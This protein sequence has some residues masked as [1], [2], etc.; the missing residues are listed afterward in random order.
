[1]RLLKKV[2]RARIFCAIVCIVASAGSTVYGADKENC[3][4]CHKYRFLGRIDED[5]KRKNY[6][7]NENAYAMSLHKD[8]PCRDCHT[9]ITKLPHDPVTEEVNC[10]NECH[11]KPPFAE[12]NFS[13]KKIIEVYNQSVHGIKPNDPPELRAAKPY[14]KYCHLNPLFERVDE[15]TISYEKTLQRCLNCHQEKGVTEA[16]LHISHRLRHKT[17][18]SPQAIVQLCNVRC[19]ADVQLMKK[20][21]ISKESLEAVETYEKSIHGKAVAL[22]SN[23]AADCVS[24][25]STTAIHDI[26]KKDDPKSMVNKGNL[27]KTCNQCHEHVTEKFVKIDVHSTILPEEKPGLYYLNIALRFVMYGTVGA[28]LSLMLLEIRGRKMDGIKW[29]LRRGTTWRGKSRRRAKD[30]GKK[31]DA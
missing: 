31:E 3:L 20:F 1:M 24:C 22:G 30:T 13:H 29:Q 9:S 27:I 5:G 26:Y 28:L 23:E 19:H 2:R 6:N 10:A 11:I 18:R 12:E 8:V 25:H 14:C 4:M 15:K 7:V 16:Y 21:N 17:S